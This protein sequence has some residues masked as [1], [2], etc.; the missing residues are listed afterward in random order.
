M[1]VVRINMGRNGLKERYNRRI[2]VTIFNKKGGVRYSE[3]IPLCRSSDIWHHSLR[4][5]SEYRYAM[6]KGVSTA[7]AALKY[8]KYDDIRS[9]SNTSI[10]IIKLSRR[11]I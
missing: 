11:R 2:A 8:T 5:F 6:S 10:P 3:S 7:P 9:L 1:R 4:Y